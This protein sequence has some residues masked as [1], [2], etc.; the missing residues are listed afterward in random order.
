MSAVMTRSRPAADGAART[1]FIGGSFGYLLLRRLTG[2][3]G[4]RD[5]CTAAAYRGRSKLEVLFSPRI[6]DRVRGKVVIDF[7]CGYG[8]EA[9]DA[10]RHGAAKVIG[11]DIRED[12]LAVARAAADAAGVGDRCR[13]VREAGEQAD[14]ILCIDSFEHFDRPAEILERMRQ[15]VKD[16]GSVLASFGPPWCHPFG[17]HLF[18]VFPWAHLIFTEEALMRWWSDHKSDGATRFAE[19][20]GG[21]NQMTVGKF[22]RLLAQSAFDV[23]RFEA[24]PIRRLRR[25][26]TARTQEFLTSIVQCELVPRH[27]DAMPE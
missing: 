16:D 15:L 24:V 10:A 22:R 8:A 20:A 11:I 2:P 21:L 7:G 19:I 6:W 13:F 18:S 1:G 17:G 12:V 4:P 14:L 25:L 26:Y 27:G 3:D 23:E 5:P 9:I